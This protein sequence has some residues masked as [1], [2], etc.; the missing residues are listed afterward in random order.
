MIINF[1]HNEKDSFTPNT[2]D[3]TLDYSNSE[4]MRYT[5]WQDNFI[6]KNWYSKAAIDFLYI[7]L[8]VY[9]A[10]RLCP[11][12]SGLDSW[13]RNL[14]L[15][16][17]VLD[18]ELWNNNKSIVE[19]MLNFLS[20]DSW[21]LEFRQRSFNEAEKIYKS[22]WEKKKD[23]FKEYDKVCMFSGG[24]DSYIGAID[25]LETKKCEE[26]ILFVSHYGGGK[27]TKEYQDYLI[28][29]FSEKYDLSE[30]DFQQFYAAVVNG[31]EETTRTR[32]IMFFA[33]AIALASTFGKKTTL[34]IPENGLI[35]LNIPLT[36]SRIGTSSTRTTHPFYMKKLQELMN[37]VGLP[38]IIKN[39][40]QFKT[41]GEMILECN[42]QTFMKQN[43][44]HTMSCSH[45]DV[46]RHRGE[47]SAMHC[48][49]CLPCVIRKAAFKKAN[50][51]DSSPYYDADFK[52]VDIAQYN[53]NSYR[54]GLMKYDHKYIFM[55]IQKNGPI[56]DNID[57]YA[58]L[59]QR[60]ISE[61]K[62]Y[63]EGLF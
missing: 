9:A 39:P 51:V 31:V 57:E 36:F 30:N 12:K 40:Y 59:Y 3:I 21:T 14:K 28:R 56:S 20:G 19:E 11:R 27:G 60:G 1:I 63:I 35:S 29:K 50:I 34:I 33:H 48:G 18:C 10:D 2:V 58:K 8:S 41:K 22:K 43:I 7:S 47:K 61:L 62:E 25:L 42:G 45:P 26:K 15:Y 49:Y 46:G 24:L 23:E 52:K 54:Q 17:P 55:T 5:F 38:I 37:L 32:S 16:I 13:S 53:L 4:K 44:S 6:P